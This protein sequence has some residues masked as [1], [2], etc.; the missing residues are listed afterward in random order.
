M[1]R[2]MRERQ[3][4]A[5]QQLEEPACR[6]AGA[7]VEVEDAYMFRWDKGE[8]APDGCPLMGGQGQLA[9]LGGLTGCATTDGGCVFTTMNESMHTPQL[10][11]GEGAG[12]AVQSGKAA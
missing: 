2:H 1:Q 12:Q 11:L 7:V 9:C 6:K 3:H 5:H 4:P 10:R 8:K